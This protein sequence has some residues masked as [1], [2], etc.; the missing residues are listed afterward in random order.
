ML[1]LLLLLLLGFSLERP[2][3]GTELVREERVEIT[4]NICV[5]VLEG[6]L[7]RADAVC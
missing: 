7:E 6:I 3:Q 1:L 5:G 4:G 2:F